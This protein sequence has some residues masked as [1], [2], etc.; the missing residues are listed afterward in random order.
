MKK[1]LAL[2]VLAMALTTAAFADVE[3]SHRAGDAFGRFL[4][5]C[6]P[7]NWPAFGGNWE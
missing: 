7:G 2:V 1:V 3:T 6:W 4:H 5:N